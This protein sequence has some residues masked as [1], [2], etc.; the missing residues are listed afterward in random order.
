MGLENIPEGD[1]EGSSHESKERGVN[2][3]AYFSLAGC[4]PD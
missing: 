1:L 3:T 4:R 2:V